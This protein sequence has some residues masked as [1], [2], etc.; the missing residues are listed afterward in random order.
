[1]AIRKRCRS[2]G[3][4]VS[5]NGYCT[6]CHLPDEFLQKAYNTSGYHYNIALD[7]ARMRDITGAIESLKTALRYNKKNN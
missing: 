2:C 3:A 7:K 1:M 4:P 5:T 6:K